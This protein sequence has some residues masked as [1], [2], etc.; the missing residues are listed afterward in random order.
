MECFDGSFQGPTSGVGLGLIL[1]TSQQH[2]FQSKAN[3]GRGSNNIGELNSLLFFL[4]FALEKNITRIQIFG[5][6]L[7]TIN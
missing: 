5:E 3:L 2:Y 7:L 6:S 4:K 1:Y